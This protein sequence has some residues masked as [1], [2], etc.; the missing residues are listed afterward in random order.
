MANELDRTPG[1]IAAETAEAI[2]AAEKKAARDQSIASIPAIFI[3]TWHTLTFAGH[4]RLTFGE[5][6]GDTNNYRTAIVLDLDDGEALARHLLRVV[7]RRKARDKEL[8]A[9]AQEEQTSK[10]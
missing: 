2:A 6:Y 1:E 5:I 7:Q 4:V 9:K 8:A 10:D 3:D